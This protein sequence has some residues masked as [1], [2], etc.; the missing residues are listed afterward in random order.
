MFMGTR[1]RG[2]HGRLFATRNDENA[3]LSQSPD[4]ARI[5][6]TIAEVDQRGLR[7]TNV[8]CCSVLRPDADAAIGIGRQKNSLRVNDLDLDARSDIAHCAGERL[9]DARRPERGGRR[10]GRAV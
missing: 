1:S 3:V 9:S 5:E 6:T 2:V 7:V 4:V 10:L 8:L